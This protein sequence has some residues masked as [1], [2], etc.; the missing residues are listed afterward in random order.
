MAT[1]F[2]Q[3]PG[4]FT[5][6]VGCVLLFCSVLLLIRS[7]K[8][9]GLAT[10]MGNIKEGATNFLK[11]PTAIRALIGCSWMGIYIYFLLPTFRFFAASIIFLIVLITFLNSHSFAKMDTK[12]IA[13]SVVKFSVISL[14]AVGFTYVLF[15]MFFGVPLP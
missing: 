3:S 10:N 13:V 4:F 11:S 12:S 7:L 2:H 1:E 9:G 5:F 8:G 6:F 14:I 15:N